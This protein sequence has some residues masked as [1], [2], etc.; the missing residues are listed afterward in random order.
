MQQAAAGAALDGVADGVAEVQHTAQ[1]VLVR[2]LLN[3][4][5]LD[6]ER[7]GNDLR[8]AGGEVGAALDPVEEVGIRRQRH[9]HALGEPRA[10]LPRRQRAQR[11]RVDEHGARL[12]KRADDVLH[13]VHVDGG[14][15]ADGGVH[16]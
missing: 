16:L 7:A 5:F 4:V 1:P 3:D 6:R 10:D 14:L 12:M 9:F 2:I 13:A 15:A 8:E 11:V